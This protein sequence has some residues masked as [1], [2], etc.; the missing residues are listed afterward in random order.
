MTKQTY[1]YIS[2]AW[3]CVVNVWSG[4]GGQWISETLPH[5]TYE[6]IPYECMD[7]GYVTSEISGYNHTITLDTNKNIWLWGSNWTGQV[8]NGSELTQFRP[9][10]IC[11]NYSFNKVVVGT[12]HSI[13]IDNIGQIWNWGDNFFGQLGDNQ[14][15]RKCTPISIHGTKKTF[16]HISGGNAFSNA[17]DFKG[18]VWSWGGGGV[19]NRGQ[20]GDN[21]TIDKCTPVS[22][23]G[24]KKTFCKISSGSGSIISIDRFGQI[25]GWG[26]NG[27][28]QLGDNSVTSQ[29]TPV[30]IHGTK[31]T[32][33]D[34]SLTN[35]HSNGIDFR[36][37]VWS[38]GHNFWGH[39]GDNSTTSKRTP[40][41]IHGVKKTFCSVSAGNGYSLAIDVRGLV[42]GWG[43][44][45]YGLLGNNDTTSRRTP[46]SIHGT[47][48]T[49]CH[50]IAGN[51]Y[52]MAVDYNGKLWGWGNTVNGKLGI[53]DFLFSL[54]PISIH[55]VKKTFCNI[56]SGGNSSFGIDKNGQVWGW[57]NNRYGGLGNN[58]NNTI[59]TP[60]SIHG[61]KKTFCK[62]SLGYHH[63]LGID[64]VGWVW[65]WGFNYYGILGDNSTTSK[66]IP[67]SIHGTKKTFCSIAAGG[68]FFDGISA[69]LDYMGQIWSWGYNNRGQLGDNS[70]TSRQTPIS[71]HGTKKTFHTISTGVRFSLA[72]EHQ[73]QIWGWGDGG[74]GRLGDNS[75]TSR[76]TPVS[77]HGT[78]KTFCDISA[79]YYHSLAID[80]Q[81]QVWIWGYNH[82]G[83]IGDNSTVSRRT[84]VSIHGAKKTFCNIIG[85][86][87]SSV[88]IDYLGQIWTWG[89]EIG[90]SDV[91]S[92]GEVYTPVSIHGTK[93]TFCHISAGLYHI[94]AMDYKGHY[95]A[96]GDNINGQLGDNKSDI[97]LTPIKICRL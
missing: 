20:L 92:I 32:F 76:R 35:R 25:W 82:R 26:A 10:R 66:R 78:K 55:G 18:Q 95:W 69:S 36:G 52:S 54:I 61:V 17:I 96:W 43:L 23:H 8:G 94:T 79:G 67:V 33:C 40:V 48:K 27:D 86:L 19:N 84:P 81:G 74:Y 71:I 42:W 80:H 4:E 39:L 85:N 5:V 72:I 62:I 15:S 60:V 56:N 30:S 87:N 73:G 93:K 7:Y 51:G 53:G 12:N 89:A 2:G 46:T 41:S 70:V 24:A 50:I 31:K 58:T 34:I 59:R 45:T 21:S 97:V 14:R 28:G 16:C 37:Q 57:G 44:N 64:R 6:G 65:S 11:R 91:R 29:C 83:Q 63:S 68:S 47:R 3:R 75:V 13:V 88:A 1:V 38:W 90:D 22:I 77:I 49:F 9:T